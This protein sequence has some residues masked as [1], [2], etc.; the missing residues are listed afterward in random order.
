MQNVITLLAKSVP[1]T[2]SEICLPKP[3]TVELLEDVNQKYTVHARPDT[4]FVQL[5]LLVR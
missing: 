4:R 5:L 3:A 2:P 1:K